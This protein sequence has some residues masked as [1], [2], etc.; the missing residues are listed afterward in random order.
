MNSVKKQLGI[1]SVMFN[2]EVT[3]DLVEVYLACLKNYSEKEILSSLNKCTMELKFFPTVAD[4]I[5]R[6]DTGF[7][8]PNEA[9]AKI[10]KDELGS[11]CWC[12]E[13]RKAFNACY[14]LLV[15]RGHV[16]ARM[17]FLESYKSEVSKSIARGSRPKWSVSLGMSKPCRDSV[18]I[19]AV[20]KKQISLE[21]AEKKAPGIAR[22]INNTQNVIEHKNVVKIKQITEGIGNE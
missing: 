4:I 21:S 10:P 19:E 17:A 13:M 8:G 9:W 18:L 22:L 5:E 7:L 16:A 3:L 2:K 1:M 20:E 6:I 11:V 15:E 14:D 12:E